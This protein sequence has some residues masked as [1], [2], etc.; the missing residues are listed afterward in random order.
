MYSKEI[1]KRFKAPKYAGEIKNADGVG[2]EGNFRCGDVMKV[3]LKIKNDK[4][5]N[6]KFLTYGCPA[7]ISST[8]MMCELVKSMSIDEA[9]KL[10]N[11]K[12]VEKLGEVPAFK[13]HCSILG[14]RAL[15]KAID[16]YRKKNKN[17]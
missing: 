8:D 9:Y 14:T 6:I 3:Y 5:K 11:K 1:L 7:A 12:I 13:V 16:D 10:N 2:E 17:I 4:I 15:R